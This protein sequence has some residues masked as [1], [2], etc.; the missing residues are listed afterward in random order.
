MKLIGFDTKYAKDFL[1]EHAA[2]EIKARVLAAKDTLLSG[3][4]KGSDFLGWVDLPENYDKEE[5][6]RIKKAAEK[7]NQDSEVLIVIGIGGSYLGARAAISF[8]ESYDK[9]RATEIIFMGNNISA[10]Y[11]N[12][13]LDQIKDKSL[14]V[15]VISK[16]GTTTEPAIAFRIIKK[17]MEERY[18]K[19]GAASRI[20]VTTDKARGALKKLAEQEGYECF[21]VPD[22][23]GGRYSVLSAVGLLPIAASGADIDALML[24][25]ASERAYLLETPYEDNPALQYAAYRNLFYENGK[26]VEILADFEPFMHYVCEWWKQLFA[27]SEGKDGK[28]LFTASLDFTTDLHSVGQLVQDGERN[29]IETVMEVDDTGASIQV[30]SDADNYDQLNYLAGMDLNYINKKAQEGTRQAHVDG[31]V[32][33]LVV[34]IPKRDEFS[35]G[36]LFYF[37]EFACGVDGYTLGINPFDQPGVEAYKKN[38][39]HLLG[40]E[41]Y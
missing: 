27:E 9:K 14:S 7:I 21:V 19:E 23:I 24:G 33:N 10:L 5:F 38:M 3:S 11:V 15:N 32:P 16:S 35:L 34:N 41:G 4:G 20:Y 18:G 36:A 6:A 17:L 28:G 26:K 40:K 1:K 30:E 31:G 39:F 29:L 2:E 22:D 37:F 12:T 8:L 13:V 25:A